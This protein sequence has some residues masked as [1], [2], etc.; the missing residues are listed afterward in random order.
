MWWRHQW[1][2]RFSIVDVLRWRWLWTRRHAT[3]RPHRA[4]RVARRPPSTPVTAAAWPPALPSPSSTSFHRRRPSRRSG[5]NEPVLWRLLCRQS[6]SHRAG[7]INPIG[8]RQTPPTRSLRQALLV[9]PPQPSSR[10]SSSSSSTVWTFAGE[11]H[12]NVF[13][14][15]NFLLCCQVYEYF[16]GGKSRCVQGLTC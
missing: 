7:S 14:N 9:Q 16:C 15:R 1:W 10:M 6:R 2:R 3:R 8:I 12:A 5:S 4:R 11:R 13:V